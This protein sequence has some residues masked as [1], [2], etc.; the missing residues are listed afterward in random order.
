TYQLDR[1]SLRIIPASELPKEPPSGLSFEQIIS[2]PTPY[3]GEQ[4]TYIARITTSQYIGNA[5]LQP[6]EFEG[7]WSEALENGKQVTKTLAGGIQQY[8]L[9]TALYPL[10]ADTLTIPARE[11]SYNVR[12]TVR[13]HGGRTYDPMLGLINPLQLTR[14]V[15][16][17]RMADPVSVKVQPLPPPPE[18]WDGYIPV[19]TFKLTTR[20]D[21]PMIP[22]GES[23]TL[24]LRIEGDG[25]LRPLE[26]NDALSPDEEKR[27]RMYR[28]EPDLITGNSGARVYQ[29][30]TFAL[31]LVPKVSGKLDLPVFRFLTFDPKTKKHMI[32]TSEALS[33]IVTG[34]SSTETLDATQ[35][36]TRVT[37]PREAV[38]D[39]PPLG[40]RPQ[41]SGTSL[42]TR[43]SSI[44]PF[45]GWLLLFAT[46][47][48]AIFARWRAATNERLAADPA[49]RKQT[50]AL[51]QF[52]E[53]LGNGFATHDVQ[54]L[55]NAFRDYIGDRFRKRGEVLT[56]KE[57][58]DIV[59]QGVS[60]PQVIEEAH[61]LAEA[62]DRLIYGGTTL[63]EESWRDLIERT[64]RCALDIEEAAK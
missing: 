8:E 43:P 59:R 18:P 1:P 5:E 22:F 4:V 36:A 19:G 52:L 39:G 13:S 24:R 28:E 12:E 46:P 33:V 42:Y 58:A 35:S 10:R 56:A 15:A 30:K 54:L 6:V 16:R 63:T 41:R 53:R 40:P 64:K 32:L 47:L 37:S 26:L 2:D 29:Q 11:L 60:N 21:R 45:L 62:L 49:S 14:T 3:V 34:D 38:K 9:R 50:A 17:R 61:N 23:I 55:A 31:A 20:L 27:F 44:P 48:V 25:N 57:A 51:K 7:F